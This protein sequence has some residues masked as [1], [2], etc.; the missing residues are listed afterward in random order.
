MEEIVKDSSGKYTPAPLKSIASL[1]KKEQDKF[2]IEQQRLGKLPVSYTAS[3]ADRLYKNQQFREK[4]G[5]DFYKAITNKNSD[6]YLSPEQRDDYFDRN[7]FSQGIQDKFANDPNLDY[8]KSLSTEGMRDLWNSGIMSSDELSEREKQIEESR[9]GKSKSRFV[10]AMANAALAPE[11][12]TSL[13]DA[14]ESVA[15]IRG[16]LTGEEKK[17]FEKDSERIAE[18]VEAMKEGKIVGDFSGNQTRDAI[19]NM[20]SANAKRLEDFKQRE[21]TRIAEDPAVVDA[22]HYMA[23]S[24][25]NDI[26]T[27]KT[28]I[29]EVG[30]SFTELY[31]NDT[32]DEP[33]GSRYYTWYKNKKELSHIDLDYQI[34]KLAKFAVLQE[35]YG[36][37]SAA[38][39]LVMDTEFFNDAKSR[40]GFIK[41][42][43]QAV[44]GAGAKALSMGFGEV[45]GGYIDL[46][47][48]MF[49]TD[50][51][52][53]RQYK[54][55]EKDLQ[56]YKDKGSLSFLL[57]PN[58]YNY[59]DQYVTL[60]P[61][62]IQ[63][64]N[65]N[66][67]IGGNVNL[68]SPDGKMTLEQFIDEG[69]K[70]VGYMLPA[71]ALTA[72]TKNIP[73]TSFAAKAI[74][75]LE[76]FGSAAALG[77][78]YSSGTYSKTL[79]GAQ[80][81]LDKAFDA[82]SGEYIKDYYSGHEEDFKNY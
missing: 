9:I 2:I 11:A 43:W 20:Y 50:P 21:N 75:G 1:S 38:A 41:R 53:Y 46:G 69:F 52:S 63:R 45:I 37:D 54:T 22:T 40:Q 39:M 29:E 30:K 16:L 25:Y 17:K 3:Q 55:A 13:S 48:S 76:L 12:E 26:N 73:R 19:R 10:T 66:G 72:V 24:L 35:A 78:A 33:S 81:A 74:S 56:A 82:E 77:S 58:Y 80:E 42:R 47:H 51:E 44:E 49:D 31:D 8:Y 70:M 27:G 59:V 60:S 7:E 28:S 79:L 57:N 15:Y 4:Y 61:T 34:N 67:G 23:E 6:L 36:G 68:Y 32:K 65:H 18:S 14:A 64:I 5:P 71:A 62:E